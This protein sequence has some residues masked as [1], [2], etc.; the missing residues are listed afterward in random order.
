[1]KLSTSN[2]RHSANVPRTIGT[3]HEH[4]NMFYEQLELGKIQKEHSQNENI[5]T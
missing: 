3:F 1:M 4:L 5:L 2:D